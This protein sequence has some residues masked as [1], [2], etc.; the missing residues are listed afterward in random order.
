MPESNGP[1]PWP[2]H[3]GTLAA[4]LNAEMVRRRLRQAAEEAACQYIAN[5][6]GGE[7]PNRYFDYLHDTIDEALQE[8]LGATSVMSLDDWRRDRELDEGAT[9]STERWKGL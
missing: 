3:Q 6:Y 4:A 1:T 9:A 5:E 8:A 7:V 2:P